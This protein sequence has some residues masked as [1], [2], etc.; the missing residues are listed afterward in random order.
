MGA[1]FV[2]GDCVACKSLITFNPDHVPS[3]RV[4]GVRE[5]LCKACFDRWN[6]L[7]R[8]SKG[9]PPEPLHPEAYSPT[10]D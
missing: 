7:H 9:L 6:E 4:N 3:L 10:A 1:M 5:P 2:I 8:V